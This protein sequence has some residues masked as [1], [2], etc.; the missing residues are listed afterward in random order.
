MSNLAQFTKNSGNGA[1]PA[2]WNFSKMSFFVERDELVIKRLAA[3]LS[4][5]EVLGNYG[6]T[7][8]DQ[9]VNPNDRYFFSINLLKGQSD[10][11]FKV[12]EK[13]FKI[14]GSA[15]PKAAD[16]CLAYLHAN[17]DKWKEVEMGDVGSKSVTITVNDSDV[18]PKD[19][20][21]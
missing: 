16:A 21:K 4:E 19:K 18:Q 6:L 10:A 15:S 12:T 2:N 17:A 3:G 5:S 1:P 7:S 13:L 14:M 8:L 9:L 20:K 11:K